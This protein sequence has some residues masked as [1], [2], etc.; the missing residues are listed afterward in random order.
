MYL[1]DAI[2]HLEVVE[3]I[4]EG[5]NLNLDDVEMHLEGVKMYREQ[6]KK[7]YIPKQKKIINIITD[8]Q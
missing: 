2:P 8:F 4:L 5:L 3:S 6:S 7:N 1:V